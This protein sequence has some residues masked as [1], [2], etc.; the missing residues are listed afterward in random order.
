[1]ETRII[2][3]D[4]AVKAAHKAV[5]LDQSSNAFCTPV[6]TVRTDPADLDR[7]WAAAQRGLSGPSRTIVVL[8]ATGMA[9]Y[10]VSAFFSERGAEVY[11]VTGQQVADLRRVYQRH[12][13]SDR[14]DARILARLPV[15]CP[16]RFQA[17]LLPTADQMTLQRVCR[18]AA[19]LQ[20][21][22]TT[23]KN[24]LR[25]IDQVAWLGLAEFASPYGDTAC[26]LREHF[27]NPWQV[28]EAG[29]ETIRRAWQ[30]A[31]P[32]DTTSTAWIDAICRHAHQ[33]IGIYGHQERLDYDQ[34][35]ASA[36]RAQQSFQQAEAESKHLRLQVIRP[37][38]RRLHPQRHLES[39]YGVG[40]DSAAI[41]I[42]F[43]GHVQRFPTLKQFR[44]WSGLVPFSCQ[45]GEAQ[46]QGLHITQ[47]GPDLIKATAFLDAGVARLWDPQ[48]A[49]IYHRQMTQRG[50]HHLQAICACATHLLDRIYAVLH[51]GRPYQLRDVDGTPLSSQE[52]RSI[53][54]ERYHVPAEIRRANNYRVRR[55]RAAQRLEQRYQSQKK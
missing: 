12:A 16:D 51:E 1:M 48:I 13:K 54:Q 33:V 11:R 10:P 3:L 22:A 20:A 25:M 46:A 27:Y 40:Q 34:L 4:L 41:Y 5:V 7:L 35:Q 44:G 32:A 17:L 6:I 23:M 31:L 52:A 47:A 42:A 43:I 26:W 19:H 38:Y 50:K 18:E 24:R 9:W 45:S 49:A 28:L 55:E 39:I 21:A 29:E 36:L 37:L 14:I 8:E 2:G 30:E 53:C 15:S